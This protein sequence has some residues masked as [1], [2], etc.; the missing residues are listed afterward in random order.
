MTVRGWS[1]DLEWLDRAPRK[2]MVGHT[3]MLIRGHFTG[4][5]CSSQRYGFPLA[6]LNR[7]NV[8]R[9]GTM[10][11]YNSVQ[12]VALTARYLPNDAL[13]TKIAKLVE[14]K[15]SLLYSK[16]SAPLFPHCDI[17]PACEGSTAVNN[18]K[19]WLPAPYTRWLAFIDVD[20]VARGE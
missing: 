12:A 5:V 18:D 8:N 20:G 2:R 14:T 10:N 16:W 15:G 17:R 9:L 13:E 11:K 3:Q 1:G 4:R 7:S 6:Q 19:A